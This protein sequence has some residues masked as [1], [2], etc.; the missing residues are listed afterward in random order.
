MNH[1]GETLDQAWTR[2]WLGIRHPFTKHPEARNRY[3]W[4]DFLGGHST[5]NL[6]VSYCRESPRN[7]G[8]VWRYSIL[9]LMLVIALVWWLK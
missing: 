9:G 7:A 3:G 4:K 5:T 2:F 6:Y 8:H 1:D